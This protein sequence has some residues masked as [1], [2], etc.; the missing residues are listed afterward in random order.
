M[1]KE[2]VV[3]VCNFEFVKE[4]L[5]TLIDKLRFEGTVVR[6]FDYDMKEKMFVDPDEL[7]SD[8]L[9]NAIELADTVVVCVSPELIYESS[10]NCE[11]EAAA[12]LN[13]RI[14]GVWVS[15]SKECEIPSALKEYA[16][17]FVSWDF[18]KINKAINGK[19]DWETAGGAC[20]E[21]VPIKPH[22]CKLTRVK[23]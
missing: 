20:F 7:E 14:V 16:D 3:L 17:A 11:I 21:R 12:K 4:Q 10:V 15:D 1:Q 18:E 22:P 19:D 23:C 9:T 5:R 13:K 2:S 8:T 6:I